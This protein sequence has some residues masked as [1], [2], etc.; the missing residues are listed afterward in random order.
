LSLPPANRELELEIRRAD[1]PTAHPAFTARY[2]EELG[3]R[4]L[5]VPITKD[6]KLFAEVRD[7]G[8]RLLWLHTYGERYVPKGRPHGQIPKGNA[9]CTKPVP[10][11]KDHYP[12]TYEYNE[13]TKT[14]RV[15]TP[16]RR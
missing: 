2:A 9:R 12:E 8:A 16:I 11:D 4:E 10:G 14:L 13:A 6:P 15:G 1:S 5:R 7:V 3:T